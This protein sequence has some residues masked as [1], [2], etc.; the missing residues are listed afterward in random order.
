M[1]L[2][3]NKNR[4]NQLCVRHQTEHL[5]FL[6][7]CN[8]LYGLIFRVRPTRSEVFRSLLSVIGWPSQWNDGMVRERK[9][10]MQNCSHVN[11]ILRVSSITSAHV[12]A[13]L[14]A[15][16][17]AS[18]GIHPGLFSD[19]TPFSPFVLF[20]SLSRARALFCIWSLFPAFL[21]SIFSTAL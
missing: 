1:S 15:N 17:A 11:E 21:P 7:L 13:I 18:Y 14:R 3:N 6:A 16:F 2:N 4:D 20:L 8:S 12:P 19:F 5:R 10:R 9:N